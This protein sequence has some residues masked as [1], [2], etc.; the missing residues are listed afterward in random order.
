[1]TVAA[2]NGNGREGLRVLM[3]TSDWP[4]GPAGTAQFIE[5]QARFLQAASVQVD[6][7]AF[8]G[9]QNPIRYV[10]AWWKVQRRVRGNHYD[11]AHAQFGQSAVLLFPRHV[12]LVVTFRGDELQGIP[13]DTSG[14]LT[15]RGWVLRWLCRIMARRA[16]AT[17][18]VSEHMKRYL[19]D[20]APAHV[21]PSGLD[22]TL[23]RCTPRE[24]ARR[25]LGLPLA[26]HLAL[27]VGN[28][29]LARKRYPLARRV[30]EILNRSLPTQL[31]VGWGVP[32]V[33][34]PTLMSACDALLFTSMQEGSPNAVKEA[35]AC[36]LP[37]VSVAVGDVPV[38][39]RGIEGCELCA[40][41]R[42]ETIA[43][44]LERVLR[45]GQR[46]AGRQAVQ[47]LDENLITQQVLGVYDSALAHA[48]GRA[49][50]RGNGAR[51]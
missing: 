46:I 16:D 36:D 12:P 2:Q 3:V 26:A 8:R 23:F 32:H 28:P 51:P 35:L 30:V 34:M 37:V 42:P 20:G 18:V 21:I 4:T 25:R 9:Y 45:R 49:R 11:L 24:E 1:M 22:F 6:V 15:L 5:R 33:D 40:D 14:R 43:A 27:F 39:L 50:G 48:A 7:Y 38:R 44:A 31:I 29:A 47:Q 13:G 41:D 17:I 19:D 10:F